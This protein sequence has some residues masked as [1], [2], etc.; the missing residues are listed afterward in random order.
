MNLLQHPG[1]RP[2][3]PVEASLADPGLPSLWVEQ[4]GMTVFS[5]MHADPAWPGVD[6]FV[7]EPLPFEELWEASLLSSAGDVQ[8]RVCSLPHLLAMKRAAGRSQDQADIEALAP[9]AGHEQ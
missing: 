3:L 9:E 6:V 8:V 5:L 4:K 1:Y 7:R 2:L